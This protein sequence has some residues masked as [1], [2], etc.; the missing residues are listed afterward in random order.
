M[1]SL[2]QDGSGDLIPQTLLQYTVKL[3]N[4]RL[5]QEGKFPYYRDEIKSFKFDRSRTKT[6]WPTSTLSTIRSKYP[7]V[8]TW[9]TPVASPWPDKS[10]AFKPPSAPTG[11]SRLKYGEPQLPVGEQTI[12]RSFV[13]CCLLYTSPS[14]RDA[15][16][17]R[18][19]SSA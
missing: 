18:M 16:L 9:T 19:P 12:Q 1:G 2:G 8:I 13:R 15:T 14:P 7:V 5:G 6:P 10:K 17:S 11:P 4:I 3:A